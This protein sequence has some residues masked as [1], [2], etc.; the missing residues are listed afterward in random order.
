MKTKLR[1][2]ANG[3]LLQLN[4]RLN[5][6]ELSDRSWGWEDITPMYRKESK[7]RYNEFLIEQELRRNRNGVFGNIY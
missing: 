6:W 2:G 4:T 3:E 1:I 7:K 5:R